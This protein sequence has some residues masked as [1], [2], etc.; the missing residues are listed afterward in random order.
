MDYDDLDVLG[1]RIDEL[2]ARLDRLEAER[3]ITRVMYRYVHACDQLKDADV[4]STFFTDDAVWEGRGRFS[5]FGATVGRDAIREMFVRNPT[6][7]PFTAHFLTNP[8]I[9][10][11]RDGRRGWGEWHTLEAATL[12]DQAAQVWIAARY[13]NDFELVGRDWRIKHLRYTD[14]F[15]V[16]YEEG[17]LKARYVSPLTLTKESSI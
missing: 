1:K 10:L 2:S 13:D 15:V 8:I 5:E 17:W 12:R 3:Q 7:L 14:T 6:I 9:G 11:S 16:P 4:I